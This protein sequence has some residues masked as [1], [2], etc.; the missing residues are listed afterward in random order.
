MPTDAQLLD[1]AK[2]FA[3]PPSSSLSGARLDFDGYVPRTAG[4]PPGAVTARA[5]QI[6]IKP[7]PPCV[8]PVFELDACARGAMSMSRSAG[9]PLEPGALRLGRPDSL[10]RRDDRDADRARASHSVIQP[11]R[12]RHDD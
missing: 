5:V 11:Q 9:R 1:R 8:N 2:S 7:R 3:T 12:P 10:A 4:D 6:T